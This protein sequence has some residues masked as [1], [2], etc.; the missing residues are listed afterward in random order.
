MNLN[1]LP[2]E[3]INIAREFLWGDLTSCKRK[4]NIVESIREVRCPYTRRIDSE[5]YCSYCGEKRYLLPNK[6]VCFTCKRMTDN[7][8]AAY[9]YNTWSGL[10][11]G[12]FVL[13]G[14]TICLYAGKLE[15]LEKNIMCVRQEFPYTHPIV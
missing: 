3:V 14:K 1:R 12:H 7:N 9:R 11:Q 2:E 13:N 15:P 4:L 10:T 5:Y 6:D 8:I